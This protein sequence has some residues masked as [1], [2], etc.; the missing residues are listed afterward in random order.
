MAAREVRVA[1][2]S[3]PQFRAHARFTFAVMACLLASCSGGS[4]PGHADGRTNQSHRRGEE[5]QWE[6]SAEE[7]RQRLSAQYQAV[8]LDRR[9]VIARP[10]LTIHLQDALLKP[11]PV[12]FDAR[13]EDVALRGEQVTVRFAFSPTGD[14]GGFLET[15]VIWFDLLAK[16]R[17]QIAPLL[18]H[19]QTGDNV[20]G[21]IAEL[22]GEPDYA[23]V[24]VPSSVKRNLRF[25]AEAVSGG[26]SPEVELEGEPS[27][28]VEGKLLD[29][30]SYTRGDL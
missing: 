10:L 3:R 27:F 6:R 18:A 30:A 1:G 11:V 24:A 19:A 4:Q 15:P 5:E 20:D 16:S 12:L 17:E 26:D 21:W 8:R 7:V 9:Q 25:R 23:V 13:L 14:V 2:N 22:S 29:F 28:T